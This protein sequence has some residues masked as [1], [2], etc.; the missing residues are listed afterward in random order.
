[1]AVVVDPISE[2]AVKFYEKYGFEQLP[3]SEKMF[4]PMNVI[5]QLI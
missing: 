5:R 4:L 2:N 1:M 3:D